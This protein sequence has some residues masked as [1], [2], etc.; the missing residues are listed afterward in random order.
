[1]KRTNTSRIVFLTTVFIYFL[2]SSQL[3]AQCAPD[4]TKPVARCK[5]ITVYLDSTGQAG[6]DP[7]DVDGGSY[8]NCGQWYLILQHPCFYCSEIG[9]KNITLYVQ[10]RAGNTSTCTATLT[11]RDTMK[12]RLT[13]KTDVTVTISTTTKTGKVTAQQMLATASD[14]CTGIAKLQPTIRRVGQGTGY[15]IT[16]DVTVGCGDTGKIAVEVWV[17]DSLGQTTSRTGSFMVKDNNQMCVPQVIIKPLA[18]MGKIQSGNGK[19][20][21]AQLTLVGSN[22]S[23]TIKKSDYIFGDLLR[24]NYNLTP[25]RDTD[26]LN[27]VTTYDIALMSR[28]ALDI[29]PITDPYKLIAGDMDK[30]GFID[31]S[32]MLYV[33]K[34]VL[35]QLPRVTINTS[36]RFI[37]KNHVFA[38][39]LSILP[40]SFPESMQFNNL[41]DTFRNADF[42]AVKVG[43]VNQSSNNLL[44]EVTVQTRSNKTW[45]LD[46]ED[47]KMEAG[48]TYEIP[49]SAQ[50]LSVMAYQLTLNYDKHL[51]KIVNLDKGELENFNASNYALFNDKGMATV[52]WNALIEGQ[53]TPKSI[54][55][56]Q[57]HALKS[58]KLSDALFVS[59]DLTPAEAYTRGGEK[60]NIKLA[61]KGKNTEGG[62]FHLFPNYPNPFQ[63][64]TNI[65]FNL[66]QNDRV[67]VTIFDNT[68]RILK[69]MNKELG[70]GYNELPLNLYDLAANGVLF[71]KIETSTHQVIERLVVVR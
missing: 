17:K 2:V 22:S 61:F 11:I 7:L 5:N 12:P 62:D 47:K 55:K 40:G 67:N 39:P 53:N 60:Q 45:L 13:L 48:R 14:N 26:W 34:L 27:G 38:R 44:G 46:L 10:D 25:V 30:D 41:T 70:K 29:E 66:P 21:D 8:D 52:S 6:I 18:I 54:F 1:M 31:G 3:V 16:T 69:T 37:P 49:L 71:Y 19:F 68:G 32:D 58:G 50:D 35:R 56:I 63:D 64:E 59:S 24:G 57:V 42:M 65:R 28:H 20:V 9:N 23:L 15:P 33:R 36:W 43:D 51:V 4:I